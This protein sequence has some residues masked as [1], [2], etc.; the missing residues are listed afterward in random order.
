MKRWIAMLLSLTLLLGVAACG[1][2]QPEPPAA[3]PPAQ[4]PA[5]PEAEE[6][7]PE[8]EPAPEEEP[9]PEAPVGDPSLQ[10]EEAAQE[11]LWYNEQGVLFVPVGKACCVNLDDD[12]RQERVYVYLT[13][14]DGWPTFHV[15]VNGQSFDHVLNIPDESVLSNPDLWY[16]I[17]D[18]DCSDGRK[19]IA[20][21]DVGPSSDFTTTFLAYEG[22]EACLLGRVS[23]ILDA[24]TT[25]KN[26]VGI[27]M[28]RVG[29]Q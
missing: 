18:I 6:P 8:I 28:T 3:E 5:E 1:A 2:A 10:G 24:R 7:V 11:E 9:A 16:A 19:E 13:E 26:E 4:T 17:T 14:E 23:G 21:L 15:A 20:I 25:N 12:D 22:G 27:L 29:G